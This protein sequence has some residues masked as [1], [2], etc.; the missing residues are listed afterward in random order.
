MINQ[1]KKIQHVQTGVFG[2]YSNHPYDRGGETKYGISS[3][4]YPDEDIQNL[5]RER[6][7]AILYRDYW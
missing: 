2:N 4:W 7:N 6:A 3:R 5:T 1:A